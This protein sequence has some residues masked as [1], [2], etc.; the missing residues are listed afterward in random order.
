MPGLLAAGRSN[1]RIADELVV[2][3]DTAKKHVLE[4]LGAAQPHRGCDPRT[5]AQPDPLARRPLPTRPHFPS[6]IRQHFG[7]RARPR[8][9]PPRE[10]LCVTSAAGVGSYRRRY[11]CN[12]C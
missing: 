10:H 6:P 11:D 5:A 12:D 9:S 4:K 2:T 3:L 7:A 1:R 8:K